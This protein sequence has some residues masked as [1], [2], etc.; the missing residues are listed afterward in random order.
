MLRTKEKLLWQMQGGKNDLYSLLPGPHPLAFPY[1]LC[2]PLE[3][4]EGSE[5][6]GLNLPLKSNTCRLSLQSGELSH[7]QAGS[8]ATSAA[9]SCESELRKLFK[10]SG[11]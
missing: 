3:R 6:C 9:T 10:L 1:L 8:K 11:L 5:N 7:P 4:L 2:W